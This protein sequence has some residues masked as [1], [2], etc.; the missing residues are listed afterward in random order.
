MKEEFCLMC[1]FQ[2]WV[3]GKLFSLKFIKVTRSTK[4]INYMSSSINSY[5]NFKIQKAKSIN[6]FNKKKNT[7]WKIDINWNFLLLEY[8]MNQMKLISE[9]SFLRNKSI[10]LWS[11]FSETV[12]VFQKVLP[13]DL[14]RTNP[15]SIE[16]WK[17]MDKSLVND[18]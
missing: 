5:L 6:C 16:L 18:S 1:R 15:I 8:L 3:N 13:L 12:L 14:L 17:L 10:F 4:G 7:H 9:D 11:E 2:I